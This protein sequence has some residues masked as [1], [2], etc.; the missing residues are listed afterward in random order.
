MNIWVSLK[1]TAQSKRA[2][3]SAENGSDVYSVHFK[4]GKN[5]LMKNAK[6]ITTN[7]NV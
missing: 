6:E 3:S 2:I 7:S 4:K 5:C 1:V